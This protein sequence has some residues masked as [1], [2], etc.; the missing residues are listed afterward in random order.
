MVILI[1]KV[2]TMNGSISSDFIFVIE[3]T[4]L[5]N[6]GTTKFW[7]Y[8]GMIKYWSNWL[9]E[10][11]LNHFEMNRETER[12]TESFAFL[13]LRSEPKRFNVLKVGSKIIINYTPEVHSE[14]VCS[15]SPKL[16]DN[17]TRLWLH[18][19]VLHWSLKKLL[20]Y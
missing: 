13:E 11:A 10:K 16:H 15:N 5:E 1:G 19:E 12:R 3:K 8:V 6:H 7:C 18:L 4:E 9:T 14:G 20:Y 17:M 2:V